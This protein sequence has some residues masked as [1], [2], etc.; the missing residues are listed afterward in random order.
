LEKT[1]APSRTTSNW[2]LP[3]GM[4]FAAMPFSSNSAA[5]LAARSS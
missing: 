3:P 2:P 4:S 5:R 1:S